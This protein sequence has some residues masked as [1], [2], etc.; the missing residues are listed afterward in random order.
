MASRPE[1]KEEDESSFCKF[2]RNLPEKNGDTVRI[3]D[4]G[5]YYSAHGEDAKFIAATVS[6]YSLRP[7]IP[8]LIDILGLSNNSCYPQTWAR[9]WPRIC[10]HDRDG[11]PQ[12]HT[13]SPVQIE[14]EDRDMAVI[15]KENGLEGHQ[16]SMAM[17]VYGHMLYKKLI[18]E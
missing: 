9:A 11:L 13:R 18:V 15:W 3:F 17:Q 6:P 5:D 4:R 12:L 10:H 8:Y 2:F 7:T 1:L 14:Q 16:D